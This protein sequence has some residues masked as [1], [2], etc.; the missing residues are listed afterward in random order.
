[1]DRQR[2]YREVEV[3]RACG[4]WNSFTKGRR[5]KIVYVKAMGL[6]RIYGECRKCGSPMMVFFTAPPSFP[7]RGES[8]VKA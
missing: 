4:A 3:C 7:P 6:K 1:M 8:D 2:I 5:G